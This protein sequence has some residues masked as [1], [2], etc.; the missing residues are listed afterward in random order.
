MKIL[1]FIAL[2]AFGVQFQQATGTEIP[3]E[4]NFPQ[5][6]AQALDGKAPFYVITVT[7]DLLEDKQ[8]QI[9]DY[10]KHK[11]ITLDSYKQLLRKIEKAILDKSES[12][13]SIKTSPIFVVFNEYFF[14]RDILNHDQFNGFVNE[15]RNFSQK[16]SNVI[17]YAN[18]LY[19]QSKGDISLEK[20]FN[21]GK[22]VVASSSTTSFNPSYA[23]SVDF[24]INDYSDVLK[25]ETSVFF[26]GETISRYRKSTYYN[27][28][29]GTNK[30]LLYYFGFGQD[31]LATNLTEKHN[32]VA[33]ILNEKVCTDICWDIQNDIRYK[34]YL[35]RICEYEKIKPI[36]TQYE[37]QKLQEVQLLINEHI[38]KD[39]HKFKLRIIQSN[40]TNIY[41]G[42]SLLMGQGQIVVQSDPLAQ[43]VFKIKG[44]V[45]DGQ[46]G[47]LALNNQ[48]MNSQFSQ[49]CL[50]YGYEKLEDFNLI[51]DDEYQAESRVKIKFFKIGE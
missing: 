30:Q 9:P 15:I 26:K 37:T 46:F 6:L 16:I 32:E 7:R 38:Y 47:S 3:I 39:P 29:T 36:M 12:D 18:F 34:L 10:K 41:T 17:V 28:N 42:G 25:N 13:Q 23:F 21:Y 8:A 2:L 48:L 19:Q 49:W 4:D 35:I 51:E 24:K 45:F 44:A 22:V 11:L 40:T 50:H 1:A 43:M 5:T 20:A 14:S 27:E 33:D 31:E